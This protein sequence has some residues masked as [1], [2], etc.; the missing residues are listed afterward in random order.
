M[1]AIPAICV[2]RPG[3]S[4]PSPGSA[5]EGG[6]GH[7]SIARADTLPAGLWATGCHCHPP[8]QLFLKHRSRHHVGSW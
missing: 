6:R 5:R 4:L 1:I 2:A 8:E 7:S 3:L